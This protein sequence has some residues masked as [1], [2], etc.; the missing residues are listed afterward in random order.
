[1]NVSPKFVLLF[2]FF[3]SGLVFSDSEREICGFC[4]TGSVC[5]VSSHLFIC[6]S[7]LL[8]LQIKLRFYNLWM[9]TSF[10]RKCTRLSEMSWTIV[11]T[12]ALI[13]AYWLLSI[14][15]PCFAT[16]AVIGSILAGAMAEFHCC[17]SAL[18]ASLNVST[19][20]PCGWLIYFFFLQCDVSLPSVSELCEGF[21]W[22]Q[23]CSTF[24]KQIVTKNSSVHPPILQWISGLFCFWDCWL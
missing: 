14:L 8:Q 21:L 3:S 23:L 16:V 11:L 2:F 9:W 5:V 1:M 7:F 4:W 12:A 15:F 18:R 19:A 20:Q 24:A 22:D 6:I 13:D 10:D 17:K